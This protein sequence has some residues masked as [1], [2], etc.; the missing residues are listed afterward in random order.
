MNE[1]PADKIR[2]LIGESELVSV[3]V[4]GLGDTDDLYAAGL[5]SHATVTLMLAL[6]ET[7]D[8]EFPDRLLRRRTFESIAAMVAAV[9]EIRSGQVAA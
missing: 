1:A 4:S 3:D 8:V 6:E 5:T 7:F 2:S 9:E